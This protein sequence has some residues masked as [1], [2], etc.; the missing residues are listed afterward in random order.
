MRGRTKLQSICTWPSD[1][2]ECWWGSASFRLISPAQG[3]Y[4]LWNQVKICASVVGQTRW[5]SGSEGREEVAV[6]HSS[7]G[8][9]ARIYSG[10]RPSSRSILQPALTGGSG[11]CVA[12][13]V[14][15]WRGGGVN[16]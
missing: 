11:A 1:G 9:L 7:S 4:P 8:L 12:G 6:P 10:I 14:C 3:V 5:R 15:K 16:V 13:V 2:A